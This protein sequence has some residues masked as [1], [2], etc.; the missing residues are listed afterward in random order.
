MFTNMAICGA[1][2]F[3]INTQ[4]SKNIEFN[5]KFAYFLY[6]HV[7]QENIVHSVLSSYK[8]ETYFFFL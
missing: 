4:Y 2:D 1:S 3:D 8:S 6:N 7:S 5:L